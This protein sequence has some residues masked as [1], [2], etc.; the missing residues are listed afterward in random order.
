MF[1]IMATL[2]RLRTRRSHTSRHLAMLTAATALLVVAAC[3]SE[4]DGNTGA[5]AADGSLPAGA[6]V[7]AADPVTL[8]LGY[9]PNVTHAPAVI[10]VETGAF[11]EALGDDVELDVVTFN[12]GTEAVEAIFSGAL[13]ASFIGPNPAIN[14]YAKS[15]GD[16]VR[17]VSGTTSGGA[18]LVVREGIDSADD[19][20]GATLATPSLGNTQDVALRAWLAEQGLTADTSG[21]GDVSITP[22]DNAD[23]LVAFQTGVLD[24]AWVPEPWATRLV[25]EGGGSVLVDEADLWPDGEFVTTHLIVTAEFLDEHRDVVAEL[26]AGLADSIETANSDPAAQDIVN[27]GIENVTTK[28]L[29]DETIAGAWSNLTFTLDPIAGSLAESAADAESVGLLD[30]VDLTSPGIYD[31]TVLNEVLAARG[32]SEVAGL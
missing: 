12:S 16:A 18:A 31:L 17:I 20:K 14:A 22:Q 5:S 28:R 26:I 27:S 29:P 30:P 6:T 3:G 23:T 1:R 15:G 10:G 32:E 19:L 21:G 11:Q 13:D 2:N 25:L 8:R 24:G 4:S 9:F 7:E